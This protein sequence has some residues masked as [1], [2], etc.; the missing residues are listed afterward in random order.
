[1]SKA[2]NHYTIAHS[3]IGF[4]LKGYECKLGGPVTPAAVIESRLGAK[5]IVMRK[6]VAILI[7]VVIGATSVLAQKGKEPP[8]HYG[9]EADLEDYPQAA[10]KVA[11]ESVLK[12][13]DNKKIDYLLAHLADPAWVDERVKTIHAGKFEGMVKETSDKFAKDPTA[14]KDLR[15]ILKEGEWKE[16]DMAASAC[17]KDAKDSCVYLRK[18]A[19][20]WFLEDNKKAEPAGK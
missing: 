20:R 19:G 14:I 6:V 13:I 18:I 8:K 9:I 15:R 7:C 2:K 17:L 4:P 1:M 16:D 12:A 11:L 3:R 10:P 5:E